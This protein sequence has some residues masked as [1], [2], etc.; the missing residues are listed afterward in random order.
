MLRTS[1]LHRWSATVSYSLP[2]GATAVSKGLVFGPTEGAGW[3]GTIH[4]ISVFRGMALPSSCNRSPRSYGCVPSFLETPLC[5]QGV[6]AALLPDLELM[7]A[8]PFSTPYG[9]HWPPRAGTD[10]PRLPSFKGGEH[11]RPEVQPLRCA[12]DRDRIVLS[13]RRRRAV[14]ERYQPDRATHFL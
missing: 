14:C 6:D 13:E 5:S 12:G 11:A 4:R 7:P 1:A 2:G 9:R 10:S 3:S 8:N